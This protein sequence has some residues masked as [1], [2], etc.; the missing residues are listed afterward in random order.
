MEVGRERKSSL[1]SVAC[2]DCR[3]SSRAR[4]SLRVCLTV[5][6]KIRRTL[7]LDPWRSWRT[8]LW[9]LLSR[10]QRVWSNRRSA[11]SGWL[12]HY[13]WSRVVDVG[14]LEAVDR[15]VVFSGTDLDGEVLVGPLEDLVGTIVRGLERGLFEFSLHE[16]ELGLAQAARYAVLDSAMG[17]GRYWS[18][19]ADSFTELSKVL[20]DRCLWS[21]LDEVSGNCQRGAVNQFSWGCIEIFLWCCSETQEDPGELIDPVGS[22]QPGLERGLERAVESVDHAI[23]LG[24]VRCRGV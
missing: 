8:L 10:R 20:A 9:N 3:G 22:R 21:I 23:G 12:R 13:D 4:R 14:G 1:V 24:M 16:D 19:V 11:S 17:A 7:L 6:G 5:L 18:E 2:W 15:D